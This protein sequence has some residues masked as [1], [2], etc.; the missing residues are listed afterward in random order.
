MKK[1]NRALFKGLE[2]TP[3]DLVSGS[4]AGSLFPLINC[5]SFLC[6]NF[7]DYKMRPVSAYIANKW[8]SR[9]YL[10]FKNF[11]L[12]WQKLIQFILCIESCLLWGGKLW[13]LEKVYWDVD[14]KFHHDAEF[15]VVD[16]ISY[17]Q[18]ELLQKCINS[19]LENQEKFWTPLRMQDNMCSALGTDAGSISALN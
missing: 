11:N 13:L 1:Y 6:H 2:I 5:L 9:S 3:M 7:D 10:I 15:D 4:T 14:Q 17:I 16:Q 18:V 12:P 8:F 19:T